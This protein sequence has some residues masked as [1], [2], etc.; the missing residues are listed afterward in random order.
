MQDKSNDTPRP[1]QR[2]AS[3]GHTEGSNDDS[4]HGLYPITATN[5]RRIRRVDDN[6]VQIVL[7]R[8]SQRTYSSVHNAAIVQGNAP[9][10]VQERRM[11]VTSSMYITYMSVNVFKEISH[12]GI[13]LLMTVRQPYAAT[14]QLIIQ[15]FPY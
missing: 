12:R 9:G 4:G 5:L 7:I 11:T 14:L 13:Y 6:D 3:F 8:E 15:P 10:V 2:I 1:K